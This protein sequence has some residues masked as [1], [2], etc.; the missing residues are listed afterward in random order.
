[1]DYDTELT[2]SMV[3]QTIKDYGSMGKY[4]EQQSRIKA[5]RDSEKR[6]ADR[7][8]WLR[9]VFGKGYR[10]GMNLAN[11]LAKVLL[12]THQIDALARAAKDP[13]YREELMKKYYFIQ[14]ERF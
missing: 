14:D 4:V 10:R 5:Y 13:E 1:M 2:D 7:K 12:E 8:K 9:S 6:T 3:E 11:G